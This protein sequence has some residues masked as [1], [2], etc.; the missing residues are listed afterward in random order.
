MK[1]YIKDNMK[2]MDNKDNYE[3][4]NNKIKSERNKS[5]INFGEELY[6]KCMKMKK[7][8][9]EKIKNEIN[10]EQKKLLSECT[11]TLLNIIK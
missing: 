11:F 4:E 1:N 8:S 2:I 3:N 7:I 6:E 5:D 9:N 10:L